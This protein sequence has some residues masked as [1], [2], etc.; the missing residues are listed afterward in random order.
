MPA[1]QKDKGTVQ[2]PKGWW[3][4]FLDRLARANEE[5]RKQGC[6]T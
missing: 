1:G 5:A 2:K 4:R 3:G 6:K